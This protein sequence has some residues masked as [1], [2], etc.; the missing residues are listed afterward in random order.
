MTSELARGDD[1]LCAGLAGADFA[2]G[3]GPHGADSLRGLES[4][5]AGRAS[6][7]DNLS[8]PHGVVGDA[9]EHRP[10]PP[11]IAPRLSGL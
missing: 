4:G 10:L 11:T 5:G 2:P 8:R 6:P 9:L 7:G 3:W 1:G